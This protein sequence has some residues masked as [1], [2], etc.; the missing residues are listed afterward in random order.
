MRLIFVL[1]LLAGLMVIGCDS[2]NETT[3]LP[4]PTATVTESDIS[5]IPDATPIG[6]TPSPEIT[7]D[8]S[9]EIL[10]SEEGPVSVVLTSD[11]LTITNNSP[12]VV[13]YYVFPVDL[14]GLIDWF[15][16]E[17]P[18]QCD[19]YNSIEAGK[20]VRMGIQKNAA[21][22]I[23][24]WWQLIHYPDGATSADSVHE[25]LIEIP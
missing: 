16:C 7:H 12:E 20:D 22:L 5:D 19:G 17:N 2:G 15:P 8:E 3:P 10:F 24:Y 13:Y 23:V 9:D 1:V 21:D 6:I 4:T 25:I 11:A 14:I 18:E